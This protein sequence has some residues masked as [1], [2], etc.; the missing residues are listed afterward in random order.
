MLRKTGEKFVDYIIWQLRENKVHLKLKEVHIRVKKFGEDG[1]SS[2]K[3]K[4]M[5]P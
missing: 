3:F 4:M 1:K 2:Q 5:V